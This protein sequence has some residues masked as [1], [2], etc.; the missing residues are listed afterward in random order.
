MKKAVP[1]LKGI[2]DYQI[3]ISYK[4]VQLGIFVNIDSHEQLHL[5]E[6]F[7]NAFPCGSDSYRR[8][9]L[10]VRES[11][12]PF[13]LKSSRSSQPLPQETAHTKPSVA[14]SKLKPKHFSHHPMIVMNQ[15]WLALSTGRILR[16]NSC[17]SPAAR[18]ITF[19]LFETEVMLLAIAVNSQYS[20][21]KNRLLRQ[22]IEIWIATCSEQ[23]A[24]QNTNI[25]W[26]YCKV[27]RK[28]T[29]GFTEIT[30]HL[31]GEYSCL[32]LVLITHN[33]WCY[34]YFF[35]VSIFLFMIILHKTNESEI[36]H[37][38]SVPTHVWVTLIKERLSKEDCISKVCYILMYVHK[39]FWKKHN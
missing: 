27:A 23:T 24:N 33:L 15:S 21:M 22:Q 13:L 29:T 8:V 12:S 36:F 30:Q 1:V 32:L 14:E 11:D 37:F 5:Q 7:R 4:D 6:T 18:E 35:L 9:H 28:R 10:K 3:R 39:Q 17:F 31:Q 19:S 38:Q 26:Q 34:F 16:K 25:A 2:P 20:N